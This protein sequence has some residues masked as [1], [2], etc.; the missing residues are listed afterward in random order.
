MLQT[1]EQNAIIIYVLEIQRK[2]GTT[3]TTL[4][5]KKCVIREFCT[6]LITAKLNMLT[7]RITLVHTFHMTSNEN[8]TV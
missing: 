3:I 6:N 4:N 5:T 2:S 8:N 7:N 1:H